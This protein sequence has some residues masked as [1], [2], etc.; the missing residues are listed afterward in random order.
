MNATN[1]APSFF[2]QGLTHTATVPEA[3]EPDPL[4]QRD[5]IVEYIGDDPATQR[6]VFHLCLDLLVTSLPRLRQAV[7]T[8]DV[9]TLRRLAHIARGSLGMLG[10]PTL[11]ELGEDIEYHYNDLGAERWRQRCES[12]YE[13]LARLQQELQVCVAA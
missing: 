3:S 9:A 2:L 8:G 1:Y 10:L 6:Q 11:C 5:K 12:L 13:L 7:D 4:M